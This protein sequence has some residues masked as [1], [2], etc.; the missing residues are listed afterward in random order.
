CRERSWFL[1]GRNIS[2]SFSARARA[3]ARVAG[4]EAGSQEALAQFD[5]TVLRSLEETETALSG[6][7]NA[8]RRREA[9]RAARDQAQVAARI[10]RAQQREGQVD[11]LVLLDAE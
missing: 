6:Y 7:A 10:V 11:S 4:A 5:G 3:R 9:L 1:F 2:C 8:L